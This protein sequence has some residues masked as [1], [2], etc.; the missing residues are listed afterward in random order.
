ML[1]L[2]VTFTAC[3]NQTFIS[4][5]REHSNAGLEILQL[6]GGECTV[7]SLVTR[8]YTTR[9][10]P[11]DMVMNTKSKYNNRLIAKLVSIFADVEERRELGSYSSTKLGTEAKLCGK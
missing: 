3:R 9:R 2:Y 8:S 7:P 1:A 4:S 10:P 11:Y 5:A 6:S